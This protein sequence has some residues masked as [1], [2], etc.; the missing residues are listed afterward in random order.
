MTA[1]L[2]TN[3]AIAYI[4]GIAGFSATITAM[5]PDADA[6]DVWM[7]LLLG[8]IWPVMV[9]LLVPMLPSIM[10]VASRRKRGRRR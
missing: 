3:G 6:W 10:I 1:E 9:A 7:S 8:L 5:T 2:I 4:L